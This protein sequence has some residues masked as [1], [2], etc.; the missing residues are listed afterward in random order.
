MTKKNYFEDLLSDDDLL[1][2]YPRLNKKSTPDASTSGVEMNLST[3]KKVKTSLYLPA[4]LYSKFRMCCLLES[5]KMTD[6]IAELVENYVA[7][8]SI[9]YEWLN[10]IN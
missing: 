7:H 5:R 1:A 10:R 9:D 6:V 8:K 4:T 3:A 2:G